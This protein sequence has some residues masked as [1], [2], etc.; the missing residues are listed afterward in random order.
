MKWRGNLAEAA[1]HFERAV[2]LTGGKDAR[3][4]EAL[5][6]ARRALQTNER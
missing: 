1:A 3:I 6:D 2:A 5:A 4:T